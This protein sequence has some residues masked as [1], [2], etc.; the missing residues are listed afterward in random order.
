M[1]LGSAIN[2][3]KNLHAKMT[4]PYTNSVSAERGTSQLR[5]CWLRLTVTH[6]APHVLW[7]VPLLTTPQ[8][9]MHCGLS[10]TW[11]WGLQAAKN[12][13]ALVKFCMSD[14]WTPQNWRIGNILQCRGA[15]KFAWGPWKFTW[16][17]PQTLNKKM[18]TDSPEMPVTLN[19]SI[20][21]F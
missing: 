2:C 9:A 14:Q 6:P 15:P 18:S 17:G 5:H 1:H 20:F 4:V 16:W 8:P 11:S 19:L 21:C 12:P 7:Y 3:R 10:E 13:M